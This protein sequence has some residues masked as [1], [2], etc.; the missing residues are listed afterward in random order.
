MRIQYKKVTLEYFK[1]VRRLE[2]SFQPGVTRVSGANR[3][4]K[5]TIADAVT[6]CLFG[7]DSQGRTQFGIKTRDSQGNEIPDLQ[8]SVTL[9]IDIDGTP[10][11]LQRTLSERHSKDRASDSTILLGNVTECYIDGMK[12]TM[13]DYQKF[14]ADIMTEDR[15]RIL[16]SPVFFTSMKWE[17]QRRMLTDLCPKIT[18]EDIAR[19]AIADGAAEDDVQYVLKMQRNWKG[20]STTFPHASRRTIWLCPKSPPTLTASSPT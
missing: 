5:T 14:I 3:T 4:G 19:T 16:T 17:D 7:K 15:F 12:T 13:R 9:S 6:W 11:S 20:N 10:H 8:H 1:G 2:V 18:N